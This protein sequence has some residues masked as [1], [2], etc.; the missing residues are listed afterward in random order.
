MDG[1]ALYEFCPSSFT[2][3]SVQLNHIDENGTSYKTA[4]IKGIYLDMGREKDTF[5]GEMYI[6]IDDKNNIII[7]SVDIKFE[8]NGCR[9]QRELSEKQK[10]QIL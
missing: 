5:R 6:E 4:S 9:F 10:N 1:F 7:R 2:I 3:D 8:V